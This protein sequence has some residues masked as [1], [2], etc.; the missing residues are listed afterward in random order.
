V[1]EIRAVLNGAH[2]AKFK[3]IRGKGK[4]GA[5]SAK[6]A[7]PCLIIVIGLMVFLTLLFFYALKG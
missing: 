6:N 5:K 7:A 2:M 1:L 4:S 3:A